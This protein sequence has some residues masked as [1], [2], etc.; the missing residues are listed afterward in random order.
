MRQVINDVISS[1]C[2]IVLHLLTQ[3]LKLAHLL[4][5]GHISYLGRLVIPVHPESG[6]LGLDSFLLC[7]KLL[8]LE[9]WFALIVDWPV[10]LHAEHF[11]N[12]TQE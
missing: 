12:L 2:S 5:V 4:D 11:I 3:W 10:N 8:N 1:R 7:F 9:P 6:L